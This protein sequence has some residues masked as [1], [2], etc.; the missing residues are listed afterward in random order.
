MPEVVPTVRENIVKISAGRIVTVALLL[1]PF[2]VFASSEDVGVFVAHPSPSPDGTQVVFEANF[3][4]VNGPINL[5]ISRLNGTGLHQLTQNSS[6]DETPA[7]SPSGKFI[8]F[9]SSHQGVSDIWVIAPD[10]SGLKQLTSASLNNVQPSWYPDSGRIAFVSDRGGSRDIWTMNADGTVVQRL[11][12][13]P[14]QETHPS[15]SPDGTKIVFAAASRSTVGPF[16]TTSLYVVN[17]DGSN[18]TQLTESDGVTND[19]NPQWTSIG[20][21]FSSDRDQD[22]GQSSPWIVQPDGSEI[23]ELSTVPALDPVMLSSGQILFSDDFSTLSTET[24]LSHI[25]VLDPT[26]GIKTLVT[27]VGKPFEAGDVNNDNAINCNDLVAMK[28]A[29]GKR[30]GT[31]GFNPRSDVNVDGI[32]DVRDVAITSRKLVAG[33]KCK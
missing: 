4:D 27:S 5:W 17:S 21:L 18:L 23:H 7:W 13:L 26:N 33:T 22:V 25:T 2:C 1:L 15:F 14:G 6:D 11:T 3:S 9:S 30:F 8:A 29:L 28:A 12:N 19:L 16:I 20:I 24:A 31:V 10:G 32:V